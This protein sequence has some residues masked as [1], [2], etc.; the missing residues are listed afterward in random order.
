MKTTI[1]QATEQAVN[2]AKRYG[3]SFYVVQGEKYTFAVVEA[4]FIDPEYAYIIAQFFPQGT[5]N[6]YVKTY[7]GPK[8]K[9][10]ELP[11]GFIGG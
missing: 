9:A 3:K 7:E 6:G 5:D 1:E 10:K 4:R 8:A 11:I 2:A